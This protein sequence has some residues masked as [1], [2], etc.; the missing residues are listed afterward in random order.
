MSDMQALAKSIRKAKKRLQLM[1]GV[2]YTVYIQTKTYDL[3]KEVSCLL[4]KKV[5]MHKM[6]KRK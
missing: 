2:S 1:R 5:I 3:T 6:K 4:H